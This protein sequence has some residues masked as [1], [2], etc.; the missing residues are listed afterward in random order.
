M[1]CNH[2][3]LSKL[4]PDLYQCINCDE[5]FDLEETATE[6]MAMPIGLAS[7]MVDVAPENEAR[8]EDIEDSE[9]HQV[10]AE[11]NEEN[12]SDEPSP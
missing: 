10:L 12:E 1:T 11:A 5:E 2:R 6:E 7:E 3:V 4:L 9:P 8:P